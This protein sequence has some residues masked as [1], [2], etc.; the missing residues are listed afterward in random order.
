MEALKFSRDHLW[1]RV[2]GGRATI[3]F[4]D[5]GQGELGEIQAVDLPAVGDRIEK[6]EAFGELES[7]RTVTDLV[8]PVSGVVSAV[9]GEL[10]GNPSLVNEDPHHDGWL[11]EINLEDD[12]DLEDLMDAEEYEALVGEA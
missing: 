9:N 3:G 8:A 12:D 5:H 7:S 4:S 10:E 6:G 11:V 2:D 1:V